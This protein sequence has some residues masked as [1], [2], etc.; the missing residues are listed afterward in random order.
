MELLRN[1]LDANLLTCINQEVMN[2]LE[3]LIVQ[4]TVEFE[5]C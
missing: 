4:R 3:N 5:A 2:W 1:A